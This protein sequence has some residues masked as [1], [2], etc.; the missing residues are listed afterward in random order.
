MPDSPIPPE[1]WV[2]WPVS[3]SAVYLNRPPVTYEDDHPEG[4]ED[5]P[6]EGEPLGD[7]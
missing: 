7:E 5:P 2:I 4:G 1:D 6:P 3:D